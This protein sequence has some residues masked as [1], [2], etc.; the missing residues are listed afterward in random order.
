[1]KKANFWMHDF[2]AREE[3]EGRMETK[4]ELTVIELASTLRAWNQIQKAQLI[5]TWIH[6]AFF[7][8]KTVFDR[9]T[10]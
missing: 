3:L 5:S 6:S 4:Q 1:M 2:Y 10:F 7:N 8:E 9:H